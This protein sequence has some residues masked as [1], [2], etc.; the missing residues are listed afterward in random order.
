MTPT[1]GLKPASASDLLT[2][3]TA[4]SDGI[5]FPSVSFVSF[6]AKLSLSDKMTIFAPPFTAASASAASRS[7]A[8]LSEPPKNS[9]S[10]FAGKSGMF[11]MRRISSSVS[12][13]RVILTSRACSGVSSRMFP[14]L[15]M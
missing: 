4:S 1:D 12:T 3:A 8:D 11:R 2:A 6:V 9:D 14:W 15:P 5:L 13:G 7:S 10:V